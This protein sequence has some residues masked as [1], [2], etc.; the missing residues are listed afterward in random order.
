MGICTTPPPPLPSKIKWSTP[1]RQ[2]VVWRYADFKWMQLEKKSIH[3]PKPVSTLLPSDFRRSTV[4]TPWS[5]IPTLVS[6]C[7]YQLGVG[8]CLPIISW[9]CWMCLAEP[10]ST[11]EIDFTAKYN[12]TEFYLCWRLWLC[13]YL[14]YPV[15]WVFFAKFPLRVSTYACQSREHED[16]PL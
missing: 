10:F 3:D 6:V 12:I 7:Y 8:W 9:L 5:F 2:D 16:H 14:K 15:T 13:T 4:V 1:K 11:S